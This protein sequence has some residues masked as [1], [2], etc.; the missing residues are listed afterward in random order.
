VRA[1]H[2]AD[3][4]LI[5]AGRFFRDHRSIPAALCP[6]QSGE[7]STRLDPRTEQTKRRALAIAGKGVCLRCKTEC[8]EAKGRLPQAQRVATRHLCAGYPRE[9]KVVCNGSTCDVGGLLE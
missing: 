1:S 4:G 7:P 6:R 3:P 2:V 5:I 8:A 9:V